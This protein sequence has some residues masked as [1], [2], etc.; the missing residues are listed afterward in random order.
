VLA[1]VLAS[2]LGARAV[3]RSDAEKARLAFHIAAADVASTLKRAI[4]HEEDLVINARAFV[5]GNP[6]ASA[7]DFDRWAESTQ[8]MQR[9]PELQVFGLVKLVPASRLAAF[10]AYMAANPLRP[11]GPQSALR[12]SFEVLPP[13]RRP[14]YCLAV[15]GLARNA[16]SVAPGGL[17]YCAGAPTLIVARDAGLTGY[18]PFVAGGASSLLGVETPVYRGGVVP[19]TVAARRGAFMGWL[20]ELLEPKVVLEQALGSHPNLAVVVRYDSHFSHVAFTRGTSSAGAQSAKS[21]LQVGSAAGLG[22]SHEGWSVRT[23]GA[24]VAGGV[25]GDLNSLTL[26]IGGC[27]LSVV[28]GMGCLCSQ[29]DAGE[30]CRSC[31]RRPASSP[32]RTANSPI[33][34]ST[35]R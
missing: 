28:L 19:S 31:T 8:A 35:T 11:L 27:L 17:D 12:E 33:R 15:A 30:R 3:A 13:G 14:Y 26:M 25:F 20:G 34:L 7:A 10:E 23:F 21:Y 4:Q 22:G 18:A 9:Y 1:G 2:V 29:P 32:R 5:T 24:R 6:K 16:K